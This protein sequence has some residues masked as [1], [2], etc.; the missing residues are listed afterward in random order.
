[1]QVTQQVFVAEEW[2]KDA[3][4]QVRAEAHS[5]AEVEKSLGALKQEQIELAN[6][7]IAS[8]RACQ[9]VEAGLKSLETQ[10]EDQRQQLPIIEIDLA[11]QRQLVLD[12]KAK[13]QKAKD[14][15]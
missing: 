7:L 2:V 14:A 8:K 1:M 13:L 4:N 11:T 12:L 3:R 5:C 10:V 15:A 9:S 6:K